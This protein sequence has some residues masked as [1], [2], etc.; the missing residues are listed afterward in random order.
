[1]TNSIAKKILDIQRNIVVEKTGYDERNDY[2]YWKADDVAAAVRREMNR[3]GIIHRVELLD[4]IDGNRVD[5][6]GRERARVTTTSRV[7]FIDPEDGSEFPHDVVAT[8]SDIGGDKHT[9]K[10]AIQAFKIACVD[11]FVIAEGMDKLDSDGDAEAEPEDVTQPKPQEQAP[12]IKDLDNRVREVTKDKESGI[13]GPLVKE[14]GD[15]LAARVGLPENSVVW[16]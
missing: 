5:G 14:V 12:Q 15:I 11:L 7:I 4:S 1:M 2:Y 9:R 6:Q 16:R 10:A 8:G 13:T 3:V